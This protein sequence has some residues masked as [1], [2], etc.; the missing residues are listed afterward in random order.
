MSAWLIIALRNEKGS[1]NLV[2][3][4]LKWQ[5]IIALR[6]EKGSYNVQVIQL[7]RQPIIAL[8]NEKGSYNGDKYVSI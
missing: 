7:T 3:E 5:K 1:Y 2:F 4:L 6:N 8:R